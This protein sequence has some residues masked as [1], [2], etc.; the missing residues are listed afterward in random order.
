MKT[1]TL[2][3]V[4]NLPPLSEE[5]VAEVLN[6]KNTDFSDCPIQ[7]KEELAQYRP[8]K[9]ARPDLYRKLHPEPCDTAIKIDTDILEWFKQQG[10][11]YQTKINDV[12]RQHA[13]G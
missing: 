9:E 7:T 5:E 3:E 10:E 12:L 4:R 8:L 1:M 2:D 13:F 11:N 6:F